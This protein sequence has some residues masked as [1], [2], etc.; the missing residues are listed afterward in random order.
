MSE[1]SK[2][3]REPGFVLEKR[4]AA[5]DSLSAMPSS[6]FRH[7][8]NIVTDFES[9]DVADMPPLAGFTVDAHSRV[10][11]ANL[12]S[13]FSSK[14]RLLES[15]FL[16]NIPVGNR[17]LAMN[18][19][20]LNSGLLIHVPKGF[21]S[22][23]PVRVR[24]EGA[25]VDFSYI[26]VLAEEGSRVTIVEDISGSAE[27]RSG[28]V[29]VVARPYS[30]VRF[31]SVQRLPLCNSYF[32]RK[33][34]VGESANVEWLE[35]A[36]GGSVSKS[37]VYS[38]LNGVGSTASVFTAFFGRGKMQFD[39]LSKCV[40]NAR[41]TESLMVA[42]GALKDS[43]RAIQQGFAKISACAYNACA[44]QKSK[45]LLLS[46]D[47]KATPIPRLDID[48][49]DVIAS[50]EASVGQIDD[51]KLFYMMARGISEKSAKRL[52]VEGFFEQYAEMIKVPELRQGI[53]AIVGESMEDA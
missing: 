37:E 31:C 50:H 33:A 14:G 12:H 38:E 21:V 41:N 16:A 19:A 8:L 5:L 51:E 29:E 15:M 2:R 26:L 45:I 48:N 17:L 53:N 20:F 39:F 30:S 4:L 35:V 7:G 23:E 47:A 9:V 42:S 18:V 10:F 1:F 25:G 52:F 49:N 36:A 22:D 27:F 13:S 24:L 34:V 3:N 32:F 6:V 28:I 11:A 43:S 46:G 40:H 44:R